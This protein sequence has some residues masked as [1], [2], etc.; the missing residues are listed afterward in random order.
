MLVAVILGMEITFWVLIVAGLGSRY[1]V[2]WRRTGAVLLAAAPAV[3][4]VILS[5]SVVDL[6]HGAT[7]GLAHVLSAIYLGV[8]VA[9]GHRMIQWADVR[10]AHRFANGPAPQ[11]KPAGGAERAAF[12][13]GQLRRHLLAWSVG[14]ALL[15]GGV[16]LVGDLSR[17]QVLVQAA[18]VWTLILLIDS[19]VTTGDV[20]RYR[21]EARV[22]ARR[23]AR[24]TSRGDR[25]NQLV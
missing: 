10:F 5:A 19:V 18:A 12:E 4:L 16:L 23:R 11:S 1:V 3:D 7:A 17:T 25:Q 24:S 15:G 2:G 6:R 13:L 20:V 9:W 21:G 14:V 8:S 22:E